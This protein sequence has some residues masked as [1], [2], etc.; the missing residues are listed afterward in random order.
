M[1]EFVIG[2]MKDAGMNG[3]IVVTGGDDAHAPRGKPLKRLAFLVHSH[4]SHTT[5]SSNDVLL[6]AAV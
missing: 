6:R 5:S 3:A 1:Y 4:H 2:K